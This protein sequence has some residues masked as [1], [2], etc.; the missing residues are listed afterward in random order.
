LLGQNF[1]FRSQSLA[2]QEILDLELRIEAPFGVGS[3]APERDGGLACHSTSNGHVL[4]E[5][6]LEELEEFLLAPTTLRVGAL[7]YLP[8]QLL[9]L[10]AERTRPVLIKMAIRQCSTTMAATSALRPASSWWMNIPTRIT[11]FMSNSS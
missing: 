10:A 2:L 8:G 3:P 1:T 6:V 11:S 4:G 7:G 9:D 5:G